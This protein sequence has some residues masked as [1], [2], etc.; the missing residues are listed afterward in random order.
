MGSKL[1]RWSIAASLAILQGCAMFSAGKLGPVPPWPAAGG[2]PSRSVSVVVAV[3]SAVNGKATDAQPAY[4]DV[5]REQTLRAYRD[6]GLFS[7]VSSGSAVADRRAEVRI[8]DRGEVSTV[9]AFITGLTLFLVP[10]SASVELT[11]SLTVKDQNGRSVGTF[12]KSED[13]T[14]WQHLTMLFVMPFNSPRSVQDETL[15]DL[16]RA[17]IVDAHRAGAI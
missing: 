10:S 1:G 9:M 7:Q 3:D 8:S 16:N 5:C 13:L 17:A 15:Y 6:S 4:I 2:G 11:V 14:M 12:V